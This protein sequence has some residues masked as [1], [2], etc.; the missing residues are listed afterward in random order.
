MSFQMKSA[1]A[2][3]AVLALYSGAFAARAYE[4][5]PTASLTSLRSLPVS[6]GTSHTSS[7]GPEAV[8]YSA[9]GFESFATGNLS[10]QNGF[11]GATVATRFTVGATSGVGGTQGV[12]AVAGGTGSVTDW[13]WP[14]V[15][16]TPAAGEVVSVNFDIARTVAATAAASSTVYAIDI[17]DGV[18]GARLTRLGLS[19]NSSTNAIGVSVVAPF[20]TTTSQ[21]D[22]TVTTNFNVTIASGL[23]ASTFYNLEPRLNFATKKVDIYSNNALF[24]GNIPFAYSTSSQTNFGDAD[25]SVST[26]T[27]TATGADA[28]FFDNY[29]V[30]TIAIPEPTTLGLLAGVGLV[31]LRR[32]SR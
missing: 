27:T 14:D 24:V 31:A 16:Y 9:G 3:A 1:A 2:I 25:I 15:V 30:S 5:F 20:N 7:N 12:T 6:T 8:L 11:G 22:P 10:G 19:R 32:K 18:S 17:F 13:V 21:F 28:G 29:V 23:T 26:G 4:A